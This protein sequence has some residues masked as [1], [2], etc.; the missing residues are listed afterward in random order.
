M[1]LTE[2]IA[3]D[4][5][6]PFCFYWFMYTF[7]LIRILFFR[8]RLNSYLSEIIYKQWWQ[9]SDIKAS[10]EI[11]F[12]LTFEMAKEEGVFILVLIFN[13]ISVWG[14]IGLWITSVWCLELC[15]VTLWTCSIA[16]R[17]AVGEVKKS[18]QMT[19]GHFGGFNRC[20]SHRNTVMETLSTPFCFNYVKVFVWSCNRQSHAR[21]NYFG[22][23]WRF[24]LAQAST[25]W[26]FKQNMQ[27]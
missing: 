9:T 13:D 8:P 14:C 26:N 22:S 1:Y 10:F 19:L 7:L 23:K 20:I 12:Y 21:D 4:H 17:V 2:S 6:H 15:R 11:I 24:I 16:F 3:V 25:K 5:S 27:K 18:R